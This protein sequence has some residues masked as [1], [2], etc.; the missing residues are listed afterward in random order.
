MKLYITNHLTCSNCYVDVIYEEGKKETIYGN[1]VYEIA[2][3]IYNYVKDKPCDIFVDRFGS[4]LYS[5]LIS[6]GLNVNELCGC[7]NIK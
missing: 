6:K 1:D 5:L 2:D 3:K 4:A 7:K